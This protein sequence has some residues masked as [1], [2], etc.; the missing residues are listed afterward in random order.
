M[1]QVKYQDALREATREEMLRDPNVLVIGQD[2]G[3]FEGNFKVTAGLLK[4]FGPKR[5][6]DTPLCELGP[7]GMAVGA[8]IAGLRPIMEVAYMDF[9]CMCMDPIVNQAAK[10]RYMFGGKVKVPVVFRFGFGPG[11]QRAAQHSQNFEAWLTHVPGLKVAIPSDSYDAKGLLKT[12]IRDDSPVAFIEHKMLYGVASEMPD[13]D[14]EYTIPFGQAKVK[15]EGTDVTIVAISKMVGESLKAAEIL[16]Q[17]GISAEV[18]DPRTLVPLDEE[19]L[20]TSARK[21]GRVI[22]AHD[23]VKRGGIGGEL[24][25]VIS[26]DE[27]TFRSLKAPIRRVFALDLPLPFNAG[28]EKMVLPDA[29]KIAQAA[30]ELMK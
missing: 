26:E 25:A 2:I 29:E 15:R 11:K 18:I 30:R 14:V 17:E 10:A 13:E 22:I 7:T 27:E 28:L 16:E 6:V 20:R 21:T 9:I 23:A 3:V 8:A 5:I 12:A 19:A 24:A 1:R 4:E